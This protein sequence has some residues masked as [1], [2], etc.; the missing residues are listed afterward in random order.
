MLDAFFEIDALTPSIITSLVGALVEL[1]GVAN[2]EI[3]IEQALPTKTESGANYFL[4]C[5]AMAAWFHTNEEPLVR[6]VGGTGIP[7]GIT[8]SGRLIAFDGSDFPHWSDR[9]AEIA[10]EF[11]STYRPLSD[12]REFWIAGKAAGSFKS[13]IGE[14]GWKAVTG[15]RG[16]Y[17]PKIPWGM[18]PNEYN[19]EDAFE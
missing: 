18:L 14:L 15:V 4:E 10:R 3:I 13:R 9:M 16:K 6:M 19:D 2:R 17:L 11:D 7:V 5:V 12:D 8:K 1:D